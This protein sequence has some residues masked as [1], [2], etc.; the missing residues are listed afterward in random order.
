MDYSFLAGI[1]SKS[2]PTSLPSTP[3]N[4]KKSLGPSRVSEFRHESGGLLSQTG[5]ELYFL[6]IIDIFTQWNVRKRMENSIKSLV[7]KSDAISA[8]PPSVYRQRFLDF[9]HVQFE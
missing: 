1:H 4:E 6:T 9:I 5:D 3:E 8:V 2:E 7:F